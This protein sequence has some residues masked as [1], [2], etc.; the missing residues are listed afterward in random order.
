M[1]CMP[2]NLTISRGASYSG[3]IVR[4]SDRLTFFFGGVG[5]VAIFV[6]SERSV[7]QDLF[8]DEVLCPA[9]KSFTL[10]MDYDK[11]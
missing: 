5:I 6:G 9:I 2:V 10:I 3:E 7:V 4:L 8:P 1:Y 11:A